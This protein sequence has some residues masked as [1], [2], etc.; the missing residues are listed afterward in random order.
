MLTGKQ[1]TD[2]SV[3]TGTV[4]QLRNTFCVTRH[5]NLTPPAHAHHYLKKKKPNLLAG[6]RPLESP[7]LELTVP[8]TR[9]LYDTCPAGQRGAGRRK[10]LAHSHQSRSDQQDRTKA[11]SASG[12]V[13]DT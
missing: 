9:H 11:S 4:M 13:T 3:A 8:P 10:A 6:A 2:N 5:T 1:L 7:G 12:S